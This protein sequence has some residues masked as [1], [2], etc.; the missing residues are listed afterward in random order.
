MIYTIGWKL[1]YENYIDTDK[2]PRKRKGGSVWRTRKEARKYA[3]K[4]YR[5]YGVDAVWNK[6]TKV[7]KNSYGA[8]HELKRNAKLIRL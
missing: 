5:V 4:G 6:D 3:A 1:G 2:N 8:W 7:D